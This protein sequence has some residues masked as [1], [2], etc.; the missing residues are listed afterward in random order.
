MV[1]III[2]TYNRAYLLS[3]TLNSVQE[4]TYTNWECIIVDDGSTDNTEALVLEYI[5]KDSRFKYFKRPDNRNK[6]AAA[7]RNYGFELAEGKFVN[8]FDSDDIM[9]P[10]KL[11]EQVQQ[12]QNSTDLLSVCLSQ[13]FE[14]RPNNIV[15]MRNTKTYS[16][17]FFN[18]FIQKKIKWLTPEPLIRKSFLLE[19]HIIWNEHLA[20]CDDRDYMLK[21]FS[22]VNTYQYIDKPLVSIRKHSNNISSTPN[23]S[24]VLADFMVSL[25]SLKEY[26][27]LLNNESVRFLAKRMQLTYQK[28]LRYKYYR[29][30]FKILYLLLVEKVKLSFAEK[31]KMILAFGSY[32]LFNK[33]EKFFSK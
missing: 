20:E 30:S 32:C 22:I 21:V 28:S 31:L 27:N 23:A 9:L 7:S 29:S 17:D 10:T 14:E 15:G 5:K 19:N 8:F 11:E 4:Q 1:S 13:V 24:K 18:D 6:G 16:K 12:L 3:D 26:N 33:G 25:T 2:P